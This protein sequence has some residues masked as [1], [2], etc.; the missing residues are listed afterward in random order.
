M[1]RVIRNRDGSYFKRGGA[2]TTY[3]EEAEKFPDAGEV[4]VAR[5][6]YHLENVD[7]VLVIWDQP[8]QGW[9]MVLPL[10]SN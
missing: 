9:D 6:N 10:S 5:Y 1:T 2:W 4:L 3:F 7:L 8:C